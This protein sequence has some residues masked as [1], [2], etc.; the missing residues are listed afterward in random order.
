MQAQFIYNL[1]EEREEFELHM[2][3]SSFNCAIH[4][5]N[6]WLRDICKHGDPSTVDAQIARDKL[7]EC[8]KEYGVT[9]Q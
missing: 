7:W 2:Q 1:P 8:L 4:E 9:I 3:A 6:Q 5:Y